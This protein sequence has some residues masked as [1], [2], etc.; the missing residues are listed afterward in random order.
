MGDTSL[1]LPASSVDSE[2]NLFRP[3]EWYSHRRRQ[4]DA[5]FHRHWHVEHLRP[6][7]QLRL[8]CL[9]NTWT[10]VRS[11]T[12]PNYKPVRVILPT[13]GSLAGS[14]QQVVYKQ[15]E[16]T[17]PQGL[18]EFQL[19][20]VDQLFDFTQFDD[21]T[22]EVL[23]TNTGFN[24]GV[25]A[26]V[27]TTFIDRARTDKFPGLEFQR[28]HIHH[29]EPHFESRAMAGEFLPSQLHHNDYWTD[30]QLKIR[31]NMS[32]NNTNAHLTVQSDTFFVTDDAGDQPPC[33]VKDSSSSSA[34]SL[35]RWGSLPN[36]HPM[37]FHPALLALL[38]SSTLLTVSAQGDDT[39]SIS[40]STTIIDTFIDFTFLWKGEAGHN[41]SSHPPALS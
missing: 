22:A 10:P 4:H 17:G 32:S 5:A 9:A 33:S 25:Q 37:W 21:M 36:S 15:E 1:L 3:Y 35:G 16:I 20:R 34:L 31:V 12:D 8:P 6:R 2:R 28:P 38:A 29:F 13:L 23:N 18:L 7:P 40:S 11:V 26:P 39:V 19:D 27:S 41:K 30:R 24:A 14:N